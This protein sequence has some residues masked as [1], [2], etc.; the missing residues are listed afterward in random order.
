MHRIAAFAFAMAILRCQW[1]HRC[2]ATLGKFLIVLYSKPLWRKE[3]GSKGGKAMCA[4]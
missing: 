2:V 4:M 1:R 3:N